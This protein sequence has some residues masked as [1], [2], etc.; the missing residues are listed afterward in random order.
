MIGRVDPGV[1]DSMQPAPVHELGVGLGAALGV[2]VGLGVDVGVGLGLAP[3][4]DARRSR[5]RLPPLMKLEL[6]LAVSPLTL[7][8]TVASA[9]PQPGC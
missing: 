6:G 7:Y 4:L 3:E 1:G 5:L 9:V 8:T 2:G